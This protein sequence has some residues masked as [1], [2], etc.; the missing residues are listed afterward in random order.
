MV[1]EQLGPFGSSFHRWVMSGEHFL[2]L[3]REQAGGRRRENVKLIQTNWFNT[4]EIETPNSQLF[5]MKR[6]LR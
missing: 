3:C 2:F 5:T 1:S 4:I 6:Q